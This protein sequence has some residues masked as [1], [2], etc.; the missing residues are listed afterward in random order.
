M[1][2]QMEYVNRI[3]NQYLRNFMNAVQRDWVDC[4][5]LEKFSY[6]VGMHLAT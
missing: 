2:G 6:N 1:D 4:V 3:L 5:G